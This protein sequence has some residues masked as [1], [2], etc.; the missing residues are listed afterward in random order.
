[1]KESRSNLILTQ[2]LLISGALNMVF[3][4]LFYF[5]VVQ[6]GPLYLNFHQVKAASLEAKESDTLISKSYSELH[7]LS[8][9]ELVAQL[10]NETPLDDG[11]KTRDIALALLIEK[12][13]FD[14]K[15]AILGMEEPKAMRSFKVAANDT[16]AHLSLYSDL[17]PTHFKAVNEFAKQEKFPFTSEGMALKGIAQP[18]PPPVQI[19]K[20]EEPTPKKVHVV[21]EGESLWRI[22]R[23]H[24]IDVDKLRAH[25]NLRSDQ[26]RTGQKLLL[27]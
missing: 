13:H 27:P 21:Q 14:F 23:L 4:A 18:E 24:K 11:F 3:L 26:I 7:A 9:E 22:S 16:V 15:R 17:T 6:E 12:H 10:D 19:V 20:V 8:M 25:N 2:A 5:L 1:M